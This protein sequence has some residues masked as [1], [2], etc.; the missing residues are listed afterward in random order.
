MASRIGFATQIDQFQS[1]HGEE[2][3]DYDHAWEVLFA[4][5]GPHMAM[6]DVGLGPLPGKFPSFGVRQ[7]VLDKHA[8]SEKS[9]SQ[10]ANQKTE[11]VSTCVLCKLAF[12]SKYDDPNFGTIT[13]TRNRRNKFFCNTCDMFLRICPGQVTLDMPVLV[14]DVKHSR[15]IRN[16]P[17]ISIQEYSQLLSDFQCLTAAIIQKNLGMVLN[18]V[19]DAVIGIWPSGFIP[20]EL[21]EKYGWNPDNPAKLSARFAQKAAQELAN[22]STSKFRGNS[23]PFKGALDCTE[24]SIFSVQTQKKVLQYE[25]LD[26]IDPLAG[27][28]LVDGEGN[29]MLGVELET[30]IEKELQKGPTSIDVAGE[31]IELSSELSGHDLL[32]IG[33]FAITHRLDQIAENTNYDYVKVPDFGTPFRIVKPK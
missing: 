8:Y 2:T 14:V 31:A 5:E 4:Y 30:D 27:S 23:L 6:R 11:P 9:I 17:S 18:T 19:G 21:R 33:D 29:L 26:I 12:G 3:L 22:S 25:L 28:P 7:V 13:V 16:D 10:V 20:M 1:L 32:S 24:M 15:K